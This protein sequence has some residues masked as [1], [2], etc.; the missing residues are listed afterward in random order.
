MPP[1]MRTRHPL[2]ALLL[3]ALAGLL[4]PAGAQAA[5]TTKYPSVTKI[6]PMSAGIG[7]TLTITGKNFRAGK[8]KNTVVFRRAG[9]RAM[10]V[11]A[12][13][14]AT[15]KTIKVVVP[16]KLLPQLTQRSGQPV[17]TRFRIRVLAKRFGKAYT[18][19]SKSPVIGPL[20]TQAK[21]TADDCDGDGVKNA[22]DTD[23]DNDLASDTVEG[24]WKTNVCSADSD[25]D[26]MSDM[27]EQESAVDR[28][29]KALPS[30]VARPYP[31]ALNRDDGLKDH[32]G[33]GL[34]NVEE[35]AAWATSSGILRADRSNDPYFSRLN[36]SGGNPNSDGRAA[37]T[38]AEPRIPGK[39]PASAS[40]YY[41]D[42]DG[43]GFLSD[44]ER[45]ADG[46]GI[47][48]VDEERNGGG[49]VARCLS[50]ATDAE[51]PIFYSFGLFSAGYIVDCA[52][53]ETSDRSAT[54][55]GGINQVPFFCF[56][57]A[58][59]NKV[60]VSKVGSLDWLAKD[61]DGDGLD[62]GRDDVDHDEVPNLTEL[63]EE[64]RAPLR[65]RNYRQ[66]DACFPNVDARF[67]VIGTVDI[68]G[69]GR[70]NRDDEDDDGD[71][72][73]DELER[74][75]GLDAL[76]ADSDG[77]KVDDFYEYRSAKD[78]NEENLPYPGKR[79]YPNPLDKADAGLDFDQDGLTL[80]DEHKAWELTGRPETLSYSDGKQKSA[81]TA[82]S[83]DQKDVDGDGA[84]NWDEAHGPL[85]GADW[86]DAWV[87]GN[88]CSDDYV[89]SRYPGPEYKGL[90][91]TDPDSDGDGKPDG[92]D[93]IDHDGYSNAA[94]VRRR[95]DWCAVYVS[96]A[97][98]GAPTPDQDARVQ[99]FNPCKPVS[100]D[101]CHIH[102]PL[103]YYKDGEDWESPVR[104][105]TP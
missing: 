8:N 90:S 70:L 24:I 48:N 17:K 12:P 1:S 75:L 87:P 63:L 34:T 38:T 58:T 4:V 26:G 86:W 19:Q 72:L 45:D 2:L 88:K 74:Q 18:A 67:C 61:T 89:E 62:D 44:L 50:S 99:P 7:D 95:A 14:K 91:F 40:R 76:R 93:D 68:D 47:S 3:L 65:E 29:G 69:D 5:A 22:K 64:L 92:T 59:P 53:K 42:R 97:H 82:L 78:L 84:L 98:S 66:L 77:D 96:T 35:Y 103:G 80:T 28:N 57:K 32:D 46:D 85:S 16:A 54:L 30:P 10:F 43:N 25:G 73:T 83:D 60:D 23:D 81:G 52:M 104:T 41:L 101:H 27:W 21:G 20:P 37:M 9:G 105:V 79:P 11:K 13:L 31:N 102:P 71:R 39:S 36:Y 33:D 6:A 49:S 15:T 55:C 56:D 94:E 100:S 51:D